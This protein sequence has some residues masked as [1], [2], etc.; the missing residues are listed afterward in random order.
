MPLALFPVGGGTAPSILPCEL[1]DLSPFERKGLEELLRELPFLLLMPSIRR[2]TFNEGS[3]V[4]K[5]A[6]IIPAAISMAVHPTVGA[7]V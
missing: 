1:F 2:N 7:R 6:E 5:F 4:G 3:I